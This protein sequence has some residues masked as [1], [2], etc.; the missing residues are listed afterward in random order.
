MQ[1]EK[2]KPVVVRAI[3]PNAG[4]R[5]WYQG[6]LDAM[7]TKMHNS[8]KGAILALYRDEEPADGLAHD[9]TPPPLLLRRALL[10]WGGL[11]TRRL[12]SL[13]LDLA[14][15]FA[16]KNFN[17]TQTQMKTAFAEA[18][19]TVKFTPTPGSVSAYH[20]VAAENVNLIRSIPAQYLKDV[21]SKV[22]QSVM[23][24]GDM[25]ALSVNLQETYGVTKRRA[26][27]IARDQNAKAKATIEKTRRVELGVTHA[28]WMHSAGGKV[29]RRTHV[30]MD[31]KPYLIERGMY[32]SDEGEYVLPGELINCRCT[33]KAV[34]PAF[35]N[36]KEATA[37]ARASRP[38]DLLRAARQ[39]A[40]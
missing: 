17:V 14:E 30:E 20:A 7:I 34:I 19:F 22:W 37:R 15:R 3:H 25:H 13:S 40:R 4:V 5:A 33:S 9:A 23:K 21:Q 39:R 38:V 35:D 18:G 12:D 2:N 36:V 31:G 6:E 32:D 28:I 16:R 11:W 26:A 10:K 1:P 29:P 24:G 27:L 8:V